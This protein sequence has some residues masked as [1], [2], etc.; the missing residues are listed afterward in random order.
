MTDRFDSSAC[1]RMMMTAPGRRGFRWSG[2]SRIT[3]PTKDLT[4]RAGW[5]PP[6]HKNTHRPLWQG[7]AVVPPSL[8]EAML[9]F[10]LVC[11]AR[12]VRGIANA[13]NSML[14]HVTRFTKVQ[15]LVRDQVRSELDSIQ[16]RLRFGESGPD[17]IREQL[18]A[19]WTTDFVTTTR[20][21]AEVDGVDIP[22][23]SW[24]QLEPH[25]SACS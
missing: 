22:E 15:S 18:Q 8:R 11:A 1:R 12:R 25:L 17:S 3:L 21:V 20:R 7:D 6:V 16:R 13:H 2:P 19:L 10:V 24:H 5:M 9:A 14:V 23:V 4:E